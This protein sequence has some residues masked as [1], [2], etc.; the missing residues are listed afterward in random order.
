MPDMPTVISPLITDAGLNAA[1][2]AQ[3]N[4]LQLQITHVVLGQ[5]QYTPD[6]ALT[7]GPLQRKEKAVISGAMRTGT[8]GFMVSVYLAAYAGVAYNVGE[9]L[10]YAG[11]PDAG[12]VLFAVHSSPGANIFQRNSLDWVGQFAITMARVPAGSVTV[13]VDPGAAQSVALLM[14]HEGKFDP[15]PQYI[16]RYLATDALPLADRGPIWHDGNNSLMTWQ[17][18][19]ANGANYNGYASVQIG[20]ILAERQPTPRLGRVKVASGNLSKT[21][22][23]TARLWQWALHNGLVVPLANW[24]P[25][26][27]FYADNADGT[28]RVPDI[29]GDWDRYWSDGSSV[30]AG[31]LFGSWQADDVKN[32]QHGYWDIW[33]REGGAGNGPD[34]IGSGYGS[35]SSDN[36]NNSK[37]VY[38]YTDGLPG[39]ENRTRNTAALGVIQL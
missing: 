23:M 19:T 22:G 14:Q 35:G 21:V 16:R 17:A 39:N 37:Q 36:D 33:Y 31:R 3:S 7:T 4:G 28:F 8:G 29:R 32:H 6:A 18:F 20:H 27:L 38:R 25:G 9:L 26:I 13:T 2:N 1:I 5:G 11:D 30:D 12:G 10:F 15:H 24:S 34:P